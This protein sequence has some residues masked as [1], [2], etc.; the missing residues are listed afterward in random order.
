MV[1]KARA[2][3]VRLATIRGPRQLMAATGS[4]LLRAARIGGVI[5]EARSARTT[6]P[7][8][9]SGSQNE[10]GVGAKRTSLYGASYF[11]VGRDPTGDRQGQSG[12]AVYDRVSS[13]ADIAAYLIWRNFRAQHTLDVGCAT[14]YVVEALRELGADAHG[15]DISPYAVEHAAPGALGYVR[16]GDPLSG[17]PYVDEEFDVVS[18]LEVL[19]HL[20]PARVPSALSELRRVCNGVLYATIPSFGANDA[21]PDGHL[22]GKVR[23]ERLDRY[24]RLGTAFDGP[25][26]LDDLEVDADGHPVE[27]HLTIASFNWWTARAAEAGFERWIDVESRL[28]ED[29]EPTGLAPFWNL[30]VFGVKGAPRSLAA[31]RAPGRSL[32]DLGLVHP[33]IDH[34]ERARVTEAEA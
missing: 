8:P 22:R 31:P 20:P 24:E 17:L 10:H 18:A 16:L 14:G 23:P 9:T 32:R 2:A 25:V 5:A 33:L 29:L 30:Y 4:E 12:Y 7:D 15:C 27:G 13:N 3:L 21:G 28:Y 6:L 26:P 1:Q 34:G 11:G 19:E